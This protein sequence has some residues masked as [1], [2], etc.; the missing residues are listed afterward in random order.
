MG[1]EPCRSFFF[2]LLACLSVC[3]LSCA[4]G[5]KSATAGRCTFGKNNYVFGS[6]YDKQA[7]FFRLL[8]LKK[9]K[10]KKQQGLRH[11]QFFP[12]HFVCVNQHHGEGGL[13]RFSPLLACPPSTSTPVHFLLHNERAS[14]LLFF[15]FFFINS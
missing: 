13:L 12:C 9:K 11:H 6:L 3:L 2:G 5:P 15:L 8:N 10:K 14:W 1:I 7:N 4:I